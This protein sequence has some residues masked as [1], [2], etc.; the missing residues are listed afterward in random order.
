MSLPTPHLLPD[1]A[2][3]PVVLVLASGRGERFLASG[4]TTHKLQA[5][6]CGATVLQRTLDAVQA[7]GLRWHL[8]DAGHLGMGDSIA[9]AVRATRDAA[10]GWMVLPADLPLV[11]PNTLVTIAR[12]PLDGDVLVPWFEGQRGHPVRFAAR[13]GD[14]LA[15]LKGNQGAAPVVSAQAAIKM[16]VT[17]VGCVLDIDTVDDLERARAEWE[18]RR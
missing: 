4:G 6:L 13:C 7:S 5:D 9:A 12:A 3:L 17:D 15:G 2:H 1:A 11:Q 8:E 18:N 14:A 16:V 10:G